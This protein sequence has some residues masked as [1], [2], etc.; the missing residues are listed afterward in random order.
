MQHQLDLNKLVIIAILTT[1]SKR[2]FLKEK[3]SLVNIIHEQGCCLTALAIFFFC[4]RPV[5]ICQESRNGIEKKKRPPQSPLSHSSRITSVN[6][7]L[8]PTISIMQL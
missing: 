6:S 1:T 4:I 8:S 2:F 3:M 5:F 7:E